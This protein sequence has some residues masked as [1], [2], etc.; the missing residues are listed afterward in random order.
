MKLA[1]SSVDAEVPSFEM[2]HTVASFLSAVKADE[3]GD[4]TVERLASAFGFNPE[5]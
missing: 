4:E 2:L 5:T 1:R 3:K